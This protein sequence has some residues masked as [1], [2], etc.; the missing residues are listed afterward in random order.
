MF[1][2]PGNKG[3]FKRVAICRQFSVAVFWEQVQGKRSV[4][5]QVEPWNASAVT[6]NITSENATVSRPATLPLLGSPVSGQVNGSR[7]INRSANLQNDGVTSRS[8]HAASRGVTHG[9]GSVQALP[10]SCFITDDSVKAHGL[11]T[12]AA[13]TVHASLHQG[14]PGTLKTGK[15]SPTDRCP[16]FPHPQ[17]TGRPWLMASGGVPNA[18]RALIFLGRT[19]NS[20][21]INVQKKGAGFA[22]KTQQKPTG[23]F[24]GFSC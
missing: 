9:L 24:W 12:L 3:R 17:F 7:T 8:R 2:H 10:W 18:W 1:D 15:L 11:G 4:K 19:L 6:G 21:S 22:Q 16:K 20:L 23:F 13:R 5:R 14:G